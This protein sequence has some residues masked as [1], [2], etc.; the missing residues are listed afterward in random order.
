MATPTGRLIVSR[1]GNVLQ[2]V[3][4]DVP[5][6]I[7]GR[8]PESGLALKDPLVSRQHAEL[9]A[10]PEGLLLTDLGSSNGTT[11]DGTRLLPHQ[12][13]LLRPGARI[14]I[15]PFELIYDAAPHPAEQPAEPDSLPGMIEPPGGGPGAAA[16]AAP[17]QPEGESLAGVWTPAAAVD[18]AQA[19]SEPAPRAVA[20]AVLPT[21]PKEEPRPTFCAPLAE[22]A[23]SAYLRDLPVI[24]QD[25]DFLGRYLQI[26]EAIWEPL[27]Q[28]Q[29][30][31]AMYFDAHTC[32][33]PFLPWLASW[34]DF[35]FN[36]HWP[37][38]RRRRLLA[39]A[40]ELYRWRGTRDGLTHMI[41]VCAGLTPAIT[42]SADQPFVFT[43]TV[44]APPGTDV[45]KDLID[46]L[47]RA[48][49][50]AWAGYKLEFIA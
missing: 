21:P 22:P 49:K 50:P 9:R 32:P 43:V 5:V 17:A 6:L 11:V 25:A 36:A 7:I 18:D 4:L 34:L 20:V 1:V 15:G 45:D 39:E 44:T 29:D 10:E 13:Q 40:M 28:R 23:A 41:E 2:T 46:E 47:V 12:P 33:A 35:S 42:E 16:G 31:I 27:E 48:H 38:A 26:F 24:F 30:H 19:E 8:A 3:A 14:Q 37:E